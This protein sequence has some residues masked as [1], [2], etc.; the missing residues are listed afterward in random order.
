MAARSN[1][2]DSA[3]AT[4]SEV[5][6]ATMAIRLRAHMHCGALLHG[7]YGRAKHAVDAAKPLAG[8]GRREE[9]ATLG[10]VEVDERRDAEGEQGRIVREIREW[11]LVIGNRA[12]SACDSLETFA[13]ARGQR[14]EQRGRLGLVVVRH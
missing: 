4:T 3:L 1:C 13:H 2:G 11:V 10:D 9:A 8:R 5:R 6:D 7:I 12:C 14:L